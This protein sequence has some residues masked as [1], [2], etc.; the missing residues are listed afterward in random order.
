MFHA[1]PLPIA[2]VPRLMFLPCLFSTALAILPNPR[3]QIIFVLHF[4]HVIGKTQIFENKKSTLC[5]RPALATSKVL[6]RCR[7]RRTPPDPS[8]RKSHL[9]A[10]SATEAV[11]HLHIKDRTLLCVRARHHN[12]LR[13]KPLLR[14][15]FLHGLLRRLLLDVPHLQRRIVLMP[16]VDALPHTSPVFMYSCVRD[17]AVCKAY[18]SARLMVHCTPRT[19]IKFPIFVKLHNRPTERTQPAKHSLG[20]PT[21]GLSRWNGTTLSLPS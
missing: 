6:T 11:K 8:V 10:T 5:T 3:S 18:T 15:H 7:H 1:Q 20:E 16:L 2:Y 9:A 13:L 21:H 19:A 14:H 12:H 17:R 4:L